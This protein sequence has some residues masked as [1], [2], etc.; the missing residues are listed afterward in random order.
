MF[1]KGGFTDP[2]FDKICE[3]LKKGL[4]SLVLSSMTLIGLLMAVL[5]RALS[6]FFII[7]IL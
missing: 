3:R 2:D 6:Y 5:I 7:Q 4:W 1:N